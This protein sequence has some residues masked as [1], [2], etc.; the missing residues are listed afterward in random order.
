MAP[1]GERARVPSIRDVARLAG[2]SHQT[3]SRV[4]NE[5]PSIRPETR[6]RV[7]D[8]IAVLDY[9]PN[10]AAR[11]LVTSHTRTIGVLSATIGEFGPTS[12]IA[13]IEDAA[14]AEGYS[15]TTVNLPATTPEAIG[16]AIRQL[17]RE[18]VSG[19]V[20][21]APQVRVFNVLRGMAVGVPFVSLQTASG[22]DGYTLSADQVAGA[23]AV[24]EHLIDL[25]H[26]DILHLAGPQDWIEAESRMRGYLD[27]LREADLPT[28]PPI[29]GDWSADFGHFAGLE[30]ARRRDFTAVFAANDLMAIGLLHGFRDAGIDVPREVSVVGF[31]DIPV[32]AHVWPP[33]TT[34]HQEFPE[35]GRRAVDILLAEIR[36][37]QVPQFGAVAPQLRLRSSSAAR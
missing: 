6:K 27:A 21:L 15:V 3:V 20:A 10:L 18:Q 22:S 34:V 37:E 30:L 25:G 19:I 36:G 1:S 17:G 11:A 31:D 35:L 23:R 9:K 7:E 2:V 8:A 4:L 14:R 29:R 13:S 26:T 5:H 24:T 16:D 28:F 12:S 32:A 33:L